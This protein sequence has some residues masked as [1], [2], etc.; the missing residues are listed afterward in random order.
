MLPPLLLV[1]IVSIGTML[2]QLAAFALH[3]WYTRGRYGKQIVAMIE[4][5]QIW[6]DGW[7]V[8]SV[9]TDAL[10]GKSYTFHSHLID[11]GLKPVVGERVLVQ[12]DPANYRRYRVML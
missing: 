6:V 7:Y 8:T 11:C 3:Y 2:I 4:Q 9:W 1:G 12:V 5:V 10:T